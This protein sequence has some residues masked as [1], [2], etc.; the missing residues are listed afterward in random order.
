M[1]TN[2]ETLAE[3]ISATQASYG[4]LSI[5]ALKQ[6]L[7]T[8]QGGFSDSEA[9]EFVNKYVLIHQQSD[10]GTGFSASV[11]QDKQTGKLVFAVRGTQAST[12][13][14]ISTNLFDIGVTGFANKQ[15]VDMYRYWKK[16]TTTGGETVV[17]SNE[18]IF[19]LYYLNVGSLDDGLGALAHAEAVAAFKTKLDADKGILSNKIPSY[20]KMDVAGHSLGGNLA[21]V[22]SRMFPQNTSQ[23]V[24]IN[25]PGISGGNAFLAGLGFT[26]VV[27]TT[28]INAESDPVNSL[29]GAQPGTVVAIGQ[30][31]SADIVVGN[32]YNH[33]VVNAVDSLNLLTLFAKLDPTQAE[34]PSGILRTIMQNSS[35][36]GLDTYENMLDS[37]RNLLIGDDVVKTPAATKDEVAK[38]EQFYLNIKELEESGHFVNLK[39]HVKLVA[40]SL[41]AAQAKSDYG[42]FLALYFAAPFALQGDNGLLSNLHWDLYSEWSADQSISAEDRKNGKANFSDEWYQ[43]RTNYLSLLLERNAKDIDYSES[44]NPSAKDIFYSDTGGSGW[45]FSGDANAGSINQEPAPSRVVFGTNE[46]NTPA[47]SGPDGFVGGNGDDRIYGLGGDDKLNGLKGN[48]VLDGGAGADELTG[49]E[50]YDVLL[51]GEGTDTYIF[52]GNFGTDVIK[53]SDGSGSINITGMSSSFTSVQGSNIIFRDA[54]NKFEAVKIINGSSTDLLI[55]SLTDAT[56]GNVLI[57]NWSPEK[58]LGISLTVDTTT[59]PNTSAGTVNGDGGNNAITLDN[60]RDSNPNLD[61]STFTALY[62]DGGGGN[63][64]IMGM[65]QGNDTLLGGAGDDIISGGFTTALGANASANFQSVAPM[66]G[67]DSIDGGAG[68]DFIFASAGGSIAHG[69]ADDD[70]LLASGPAYFQFNNLSEV[71]K[72]E[73]K[74]IAGHRAITRDEVLAD[75]AK[76][77]HFGVDRSGDVYNL[78]TDYLKGLTSNYAEYA[79][80]LEGINYIGKRGSETSNHS[81]GDVSYGFSGSFTLTYDYSNAGELASLATDNPSALNVAISTFAP[82]GGRSLDDFATI[83]GANLFGD[84]GNDY[85]VGGLYADY[86]SGGA[87]NDVIFAGA[88][89]DI[90]EGG[91][92][93]DA[94]VGQEGKD[95]IMGGAG[96]DTLDGGD[97][98]DLLIGGDGSD[99]FYGG[100]GDDIFVAG[101][102][103]KVLT[104]VRAIIFIS[105]TI[106]FSKRPRYALQPAIQ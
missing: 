33:S 8:K 13:G 31:V 18:E 69:G 98:N 52:E 6:Q 66:P 34:N 57:K 75:F 9:D 89:N 73:E 59:I 43:D 48:D 67:A 83:K 54:G 90:V 61:I 92:G 23:V 65:L 80:T 86:L 71:L 94:L 4:D 99:A 25:A 106:L 11:F 46:S 85:L 51:G 35:Y 27:P 60:L 84:S 5:G 79:S 88:G 47:N 53:D 10:T 32:I 40:P 102:G 30:E 45:V 39:G 38:R 81:N 76:T 58:S 68:K 64:I 42:Q 49:G 97:G 93:S 103:I 15:S 77:M 78:R 62:A 96:D 26:G 14:D 74:G 1:T 24:T 37:L 44:A 100:A 21:Y 72:D 28:S 105:L 101:V 19:D 12:F 20:M 56:T 36:R 63:D 16:L 70:V 91:D 29:A 50:G 22:F 3:L 41:N 7:T 17:Y 104:V 55:T 82:G 95:I 87:D 2:I